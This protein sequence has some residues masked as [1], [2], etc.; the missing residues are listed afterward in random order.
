MLTQQ[1]QI[2]PR[3]K[4]ICRFSLTIFKKKP[5]K[6]TKTIQSK[7]QKQK[8]QNKIAKYYFCK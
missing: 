1:K 6:K 3:K 4:P 2:Q 7:T 5:D 8:Q